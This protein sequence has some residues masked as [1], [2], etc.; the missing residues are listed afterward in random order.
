MS[1][2]IVID[3]DV[4]REEFPQEEAIRAIQELKSLRPYF[5]GDLYLLTEVTT[6]E[7]DWCA[8]QLHRPDLNAGFAVYFRRPECALADMRAQLREIEPVARYRVT[9]SETYN[10]G[11]PLEMTGVELLDLTVSV[12]AK[13]GSMLLRYEMVA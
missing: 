2:G 12:N 13:P 9:L 1:T 8:Y 5:L 11:Q 3:D 10:R 4:S 6:K 7:D